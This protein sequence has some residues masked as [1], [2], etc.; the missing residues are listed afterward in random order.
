VTARQR[1]AAAEGL[2]RLLDRIERG[3]LDAPPWFRQRL[4]GAIIGLD[5][6][7]AAQRRS[8]PSA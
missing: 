3:E 8:E 6:D 4:A 2:Q 5:P 7:R 1:R